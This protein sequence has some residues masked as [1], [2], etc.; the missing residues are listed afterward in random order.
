MTISKSPALTRA[1]GPHGVLTRFIG[2]DRPGL[3]SAAASRGT[4][5]TPTGAPPRGIGPR[6]FGRSR[7]DRETLQT[8]R[9][10]LGALA[11][12]QAALR[13]LAKLVATGVSP[14]ECFAAVATEMANC[15]DVDKAEVFRYNGDGAAIAVACHA[16]AD[17]AHTP[18]GAA[19]TPDDHKIAAE[20]LRTGFA[21]TMDRLEEAT[22]SVPARLRELGLGSVAGAPI[23]VD[24]RLWGMA[25]VGSTRTKQLPA[26]TNH[27]I[28]EFADLVAAYIAASTTRAELL[29]SRARIVAA[30]D[31]AR[32]RLERD[33]H[34]G[35]QQRLVLLHLKLRAA[36]EEVPDEM[37][38]LKTSLAELASDLTDATKEVQAISRGIHP[39]VLS[40]GGLTPALKALANRSAIPVTSDIALKGPLP[41]PIEVAAYYIVAEALTNAAKHSR[42]TKITVS[43]HD[44]GARLYLSVTDD[45]VGGASANKGSGLFGLNDRVE[46]LGGR[47]TVSSIPG[48][49]TSVTVTL[50]FDP[51]QAVWSSTNEAQSALVAL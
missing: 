22:G 33:L 5:A 9:R 20:L 31:E 37:G 48:S 23:V 8:S 11:T 17:T 24:G 44:K 50:P 27:R 13:R 1:P 39:A 35:A 15:L 29:A 43:A 41:D 42:A 19:V 47:M 7:G 45:G 25:V 32:R 28:A 12:Q 49:G 21:G 14:D 26:D 30:S 3:R 18:V 4:H 6:R 36:L 46:A 40:K 38:A 51:V 34:D 10:H 16:S 2:V